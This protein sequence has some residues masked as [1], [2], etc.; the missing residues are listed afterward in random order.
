MKERLQELD[1]L[2]GLS[3]IGMILVI[4]PGDWGQRFGWLNHAEWRGWSLADMIF[5]SFLFCV[6]FSMILSINKRIAN[7]RTLI[8][9]HILIRGIALVVLGFAIGLIP[10]FNFHT[11]RI[12]G[13]L[14]R[15]G[16]C[17][18]L[19][20]LLIVFSSGNEKEVNRNIQLKTLLLSASI[21]AI[22]YWVVLNLIPLPGVGNITGYDSD[23]SWPA[24]IDRQIF[25][26]NHLWIWGQTNGVVTYDPEGLLS[27]FPACI[28][29]IAGAIIG[30]LYKG[31]HKFIKPPFLLLIGSV[32]VLSG[33]LLEI[34]SID[35]LIKKIWTVSFALLS[36][37]FAIVVLGVIMISNKSFITT[38][39]FPTKVF[40]SNALLG[41]II[42]MLSGQLI[43]RPF[44]LVDNNKTSLR[45][46]GFN[47]LNEAVHSPQYASFLFSIIYLTLSFLILLFLYRK[48][49]FIKL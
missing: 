31:N 1:M 11:V 29:V 25:S 36:S 27:T 12:P 18:I 19:V 20:G 32:L 26:V 33:L 39:Y 9:R 46:Y 4:V 40:G 2:R 15:I 21:I 30:M 7:G 5:P 43:D 6:G 13:V 41:F 45:S 3:V 37:G 34:S 48:R 44:L 22:L 38:L 10:D 14:Q 23:K 42:G 47:M 35:P 49:W 17:Y 8:I 24:L 28:N 16:I